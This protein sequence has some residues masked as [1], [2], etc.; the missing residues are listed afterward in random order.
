MASKADD[1]PTDENDVS[2]LDYLTRNALQCKTLTEFI[3]AE[4]AKAV[5]GASL[6]PGKDDAPSGSYLER[7][8]AMLIERLLKLEKS[9]QSSS[10][11]SG[12]PP[13]PDNLPKPPKGKEAPPP[14][15]EPA[16]AFWR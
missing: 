3:Q 16:K 12:E 2:F 13:K 7:Q 6:S 10:E 11:Q 8:N 4:V 1:D 9:T 15:P 5:K 14:K